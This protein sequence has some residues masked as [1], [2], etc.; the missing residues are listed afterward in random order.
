[1]AYFKI[2]LSTINA[3]LTHQTA[4]LRTII[5]YCF[6]NNLKL[7]KPIFTL[8][9]DHNNNN[10]LKTDLSKYY[11]LN[12]I[13]V[14][15]HLFK[16]YD[17]INYTY[18][19][20]KNTYKHGLLYNNST[21]Q[22]L[23]DVK[24]DIPY[25]ND[26]IEIANQISSELDEYMCI[27]VRRGDRITNNQI[28]IDTQPNNI[29]NVINKY[30][31]KKVYIM[32]NTLNELKTLSNIENIY[33]YTNF[34]VL[35]IVNDNYYLFCIENNIMEF[36]KIRCSTFNVKLKNKNNN[37]YHCYLTNYPGWQ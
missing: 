6:I 28:D 17:D 12:G 18:T 24:I 15:G 31:T 9:G 3:G 32:T 5:N 25:K 8:S 11:D 16:L 36:A 14:N 20:T 4:N 10:E 2:D 35:K 13:T 21:F 27:H 29:I 7:I 26:I 33:F 34:N 37:Y 22:N 30:K 19:I 23:K 1:M